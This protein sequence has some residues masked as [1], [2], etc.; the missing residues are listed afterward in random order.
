VARPTVCGESPKPAMS[1]ATFAAIGE[2]LAAD[3]SLGKRVGGILRFVLASDD[4]LTCTYTV[5]CLAG[6]VREGGD[7]G[8]KPDVSIRM[9]ASDFQ[10][11]AAGKLGAT[12]AFM[13]G[14]LKLK[15]SSSL[16]QKFAALAV[17]AVKRQGTPAAA[18]AASSAVTVAPSAAPPAAREPAAAPKGFVSNAVFERMAANL[19]AEPALLK[20][21]NG[22]FLFHITGGPA[23]ARAT[24]AV[25]AR[26]GGS[27]SVGLA[28]EPP[29][30]ADCTI[31]ISDADLVAL[32]AGK[33]G[34]MSAYMS[35]KL[36]VQG[37]APLA[38]KL[39]A[40]MGG[41]PKS[42]L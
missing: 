38:Q 6:A 19:R 32:A 24:W 12:S 33:L 28:P 23:G 37:K 17:E 1:A 4:G 29:A 18:A 7:D 41:A 16:A 36:K 22:S 14:R 34:A 26:A 8:V 3:P 42:K 27:A 13:S 40:L 21:V 2:A 20:K 31:T 30:K 35:G 39:A 15:G 9:K 25:D 11:L 10:L 5:D